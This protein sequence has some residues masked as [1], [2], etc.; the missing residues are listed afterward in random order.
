MLPEESQATEIEYFV[1]VAARRPQPQP[2]LVVLHKQL[3]I[4]SSHLWKLPALR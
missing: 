2:A 1:N 4:S 3:C